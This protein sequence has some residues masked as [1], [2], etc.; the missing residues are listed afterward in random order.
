MLGS[1]LHLYHT[2]TFFQIYHISNFVKNSKMYD[3]ANL[4]FL[5]SYVLAREP[6][7]PERPGW[8][9][10]KE[11]KGGGCTICPDFIRSETESVLLLFLSRLLLFFV[12]VGDASL[13][14]RVRCHWRHQDTN[15]RKFFERRDYLASPKPLFSNIKVTRDD[16]SGQSF[17]RDI[18]D[19]I[20]LLKAW[21]NL[22]RHKR[23]FSER[24][25]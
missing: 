18:F 3:F 4:S 11:K 12:V 14:K 6:G 25:S 23:A 13:G 17:K 5:E 9:V 2:N 7:A 20:F 15:V 16:T 10:S 22:V 1:H 24:V 8:G 21:I 19:K